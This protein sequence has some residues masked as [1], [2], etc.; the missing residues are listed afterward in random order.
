MIVLYII[1]AAFTLGGGLLLAAYL[2]QTRSRS[3]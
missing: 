2:T 3:W 1:S